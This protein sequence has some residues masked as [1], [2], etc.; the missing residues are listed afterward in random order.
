MTTRRTL[1]P[2]LWRT[3]RVLA[4]RTR[5]RI[6]ALLAR[7]SPQAV[8]AVAGQMQLPMPVASQC[9]RA[10]EARGLLTVR[11]VGRRVYYRL[12]TTTGGAA[13]EL[14]APLRLALRDEPAAIESVFRLVTA[15]T[16]PRRIEIY[17]VLKAEAGRVSHVRA[18][19]RISAPALR[20]HLH[21]LRQRGFVVCRGRIYAATQPAPRLGRMLARLA[22]G[23]G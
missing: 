5:L 20:R 18:A 15:F 19:T 17:R 21:K 9:L 10:L 13:P 11:R 4:N 3:C 8:S 23:S 16:H 2:T 1:N 14:V 12:N 7:R 22:A 6:F